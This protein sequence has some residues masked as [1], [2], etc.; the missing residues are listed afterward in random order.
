MR[1][2]RRL[3]PPIALALAATLGLAAPSSAASPA[4]LPGAPTQTVSA[5]AALPAAP[6]ASTR[7]GDYE[8]ALYVYQK[9]DATQGAAWRNSGKQFLVTTWDSKNF[10]SELDASLLSDVDGVGQVCGEG[11][12]V[13]QDTV[14]LTKA[15]SPSFEFPANITYPTDNIGWPPI[16]KARHDELST[17]V[18]V[19]ECAPEQVE[20]PPLPTVNVTPPSCENPSSTVTVDGLATDVRLV[21]GDLRIRAED[22]PQGGFDVEQALAS[23]GITPAY[24]DLTLDAVWYDREGDKEDHDLGQVTLTLLDPS[25]LE[26]NTRE[27]ATPVTPEIA[28]CTAG[29]PGIVLPESEQFV[30]AFDETTGVATATVQ[31]NFTAEPGNG[32]A[33][34]EVEGVLT[35]TMTGVPGVDVTC[36][37]PQEPSLAG[38]VAT[39]N[40]EADAPWLTYAVVLTDADGQY[41]GDGAGTITFDAPE[42]EED[43]EYAFTLG[44]DGTATGAVLWPGASVDADGNADGWPGW[45]QL[46]DGTW[47]ETEGNSAWARDITSVTVDVNP[48]LSVEVTYP[49]ATPDCAAAPPVVTP[50]DEPTVAPTDE[51]TVT[52]STGT[53]DESEV[54]GVSVPPENE[55]AQTGANAL[56]WAVLALGLVG[57]GTATVVIV[58]RRQA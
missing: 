25:S 53:E 8:T 26:C 34:T 24:G 39:G 28:D 35:Q 42:G 5:P 45:E 44:E 48:S 1:S 13:Q 11:W 10:T 23:H 41:A 33:A 31:E 29:M 46:A 51:P 20:L 21:L 56:L 58:R 22:I 4:A 32:W 14:D 3:V 2:L 54:L 47:V 52:P 55:L 9:L 16:I 30:Y 19:P 36:A 38:T 57:I 12:G 17:L 27:A 40:C 18:E 49:E 43:V 15:D 7:S 37:E 50:T 6:L